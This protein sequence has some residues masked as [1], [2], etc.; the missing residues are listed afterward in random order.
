MSLDRRDFL[1]L[2]AAGIAIGAFPGIAFASSEII[3]KK[4]Q[5]VVVVGAG[6][7]GAT[8][9]KYLRMWGDNKIE[10]V[11][12]ERNSVFVSCPMSNTVLGGT[13][14]ISDL[15]QNYDALKQVR[16]QVYPGRSDGY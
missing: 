1:K 15:T 14:T 3:E 6:F 7:G 12:V 13:R 11:L 2:S 8:A 9:A 4:G 10:V 16:H 5:R